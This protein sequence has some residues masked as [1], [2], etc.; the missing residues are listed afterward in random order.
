MPPACPYA[1]IPP[2]STVRVGDLTIHYQV[3][4]EGRDVVLIH[5]WVSS[6]RLWQGTMATLAGA[7]CRC[8]A[9]DL[10]GFGASDKP[11]DGW[12]RIENFATLVVAFCR[13]Q[14]LERVCLVG[15]SMGGTIALA[16]GLEQPQMVK[17]LVAV[18]PV[19]TGRLGLPA[20]W[21]ISGRLGSWFLEHSHVLWPLAAA[22][23]PRAYHRRNWEDLMHA[24]PQAALGSLRALA[25]FDLSPR[26]P[27]ITAPTLILAGAGDLNVPPAQARL[28]AERIPYA[29]LVLLPGARH[30]PMDERP[31]AF[32]RELKEFLTAAMEAHL[33]PLTT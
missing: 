5:G 18:S 4:G 31:Q 12:Y 9:L 11:A 28:A 6:W 14:E 13:T 26:L 30:L 1:I 15:H 2:V 19:V 20:E 22:L 17:R 3:Q 23:R 8:W 7:G 21:F 33:T 29:R 10:P 27:A 16:V 25:G 32:Y 24:S